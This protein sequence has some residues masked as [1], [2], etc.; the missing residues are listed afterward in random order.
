VRMTRSAWRGEKECRLTQHMIS[1]LSPSESLRRAVIHLRLKFSLVLTPLF[2]WG[3]YLATRR[4]ISWEHLLLGYAIVHFPLYGGMNAFNSYYDRDE[5]PIGALLEPPP[6]NHLVLAVAL[7]CKAVALVAGLLLDVRFG[8]L[9]GAGIILS[10]LYSHPLFRWKEHPSLAAVCIFVGQGILGVLWGWVAAT[11]SANIDLSL[12]TIWPQ[13]RLSSL[14]VLCAACWTLGFYPLTGVYQIEH[15]R[16]HHIH[17]LAV[18]LGIAGCFLFAAAIATL[19]G[20]GVWVVLFARGAYAAMAL[21]GL[22]LVGAGIYTWQWY[23][24]FAA[25]T[26]RQNQRTLMRLSYANGVFFSFLFLALILLGP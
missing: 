8:L 19:G 22:Y 5:G 21:S 17:T 20:I 26:D 10:V 13:N 11:W 4:Q 16:E 15:D 24:R 2:I 25:L 6:V 23:R 9:V 14:G 7:L 3:V 18:A 12:A 1:L